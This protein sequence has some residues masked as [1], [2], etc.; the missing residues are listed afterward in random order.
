MFFFIWEMPFL[1]FGGNKNKYC[2]LSDM[3]FFIKNMKNIKYR[4]SDPDL[5][6]LWTRIRIHYYGKV[7]PRIRIYFSQMWIPGSGS[8][9]GSM[10][11]WDGSETLEQSPKLSV[12]RREPP[13]FQSFVYTPGWIWSWKLLSPDSSISSIFTWVMDQ[14]RDTAPPFWPT[15]TSPH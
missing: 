5:D 11:K 1:N 13:A 8:G 12:H 2:N 6:P 15:P 9:S 4:Y 10:S 3:S 14:L 7:D